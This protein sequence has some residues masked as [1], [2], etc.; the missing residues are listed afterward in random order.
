MYHEETPKWIP[1]LRAFGEIAIVKTPTKPQAKL[2][3]SVIPAFNWALQRFTRVIPI[4]FGV[5]LPNTILNHVQKYTYNRHFL[6]LISLKTS[7]LLN[8]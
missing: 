5:P 2:T 7:K 4:S 6:M 8:K 1:F 3:I